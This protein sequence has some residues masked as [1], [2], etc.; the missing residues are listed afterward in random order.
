[1]NTRVFKFGGSSVAEATGFLN[2]QNICR[3]FSQSPTIVV[4][5]ALGK[6]TNALENV[7]KSLNENGVETASEALRSVRNRHDQICKELELDDDGLLDSFDRLERDLDQLVNES[8]D[9][10]YDK[11][12]SVGELTSTRMLAALMAKNGMD[13]QWVDARELVKTN[14]IH[15]GATVDWKLTTNAINTK[16]KPLLTGQRIIVTQGF[17]GGNDG[18]TTTL[19]R[20]GSDYSAAIF[21]YC[22]DAKDLTIWKDVPGVLTGDPRE[23]D[24]VLKLDRLSY[25]EAIE[26]TYYGAKV[27]HPKTIKPLQNKSIGLHV[28]SFIDTTESGTQIV[29]EVEVD[30]P[31]IVVVDKN[32]CLLHISTKDFSFVAEHHM[33]VIFNLISGHRI[34]V[35]MMR[36]TAISFTVCVTDER[37]R[38]DDLI[39]ALGEEFNVVIDRGLELI[40]VRHHSNGDILSMIGARSVIFEERIRDTVQYVVRTGKPITRK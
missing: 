40:T 35:N 16:L 32:Q 12:V 15:R 17:I 36:N 29:P 8:W 4:L 33:S 13:V 31:P 39:Q 27:I 37:Q 2:V 20:E 7:M 38:L 10:A 23:F 1:M 6:T 34:K 25:R 19:G 22:L 28:R 24:N 21:A 26:M 11:V 9:T 3:G 30:Y 18:V 5:S 14:D